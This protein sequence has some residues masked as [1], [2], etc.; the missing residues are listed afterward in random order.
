MEPR[1]REAEMKPWTLA[2]LKVAQPDVVKDAEA[3]IAEVRPILEDENPG[4]AGTALAALVAMY[5]HGFPEG[6]RQP[7][8]KLWL[9]T[10]AQMLTDLDAKEA[11]LKAKRHAS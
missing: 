10:T 7:V 5:I 2:K 8:M 9:E 1:G 11:A 6:K 4:A 3:L